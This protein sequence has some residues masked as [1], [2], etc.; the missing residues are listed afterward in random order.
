MNT[1][2]ID[3]VG[4]AVD[5][6]EEA[7][8]LYTEK[9]GM[10]LVHKEDLPDRGIRVAFLVGDDGVAAVELMEPMNHDDPNNTVA[11]F[12]KSKG[13]GMHHLAVKVRDISE[14]LKEMEAMGMNL[15]DKGPRRG[16]RGHLVAF[17][18]PKSVMG[19]L[20]ELVQEAHH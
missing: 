5:N 7:I 4:V 2:G 1:L 19:V 17:V 16:A 11:K 8:K 12:I 14:S 15:I 6:L 10:K 9:V 18:H 13:Q 20:L 3:H